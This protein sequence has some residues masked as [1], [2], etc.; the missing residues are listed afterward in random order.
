MFL[1]PKWIF[2]LDEI[3]EMQ[4]GRRRRGFFGNPYFLPP[5]ECKLIYDKQYQVIGIKD[6]KLLRADI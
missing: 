5:K 2:H 6:D 1:D 3:E 4:W